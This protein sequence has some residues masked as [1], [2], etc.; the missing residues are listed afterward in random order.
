[1]GALKVLLR[2]RRL[3]VVLHAVLA[4]AMLPGILRLETDN[5]PEIFF[6]RDAAAMQQ[7][8][9]FRRDFGGGRAVRIAL[10]GHGL[11]TPA[12]LD[13]LGRL[14]KQAAALPGVETA[15]GLAALYRWHMLEWPPPKPE[16]F[17]SELLDRDLE[18][19]SGLVS[20]D[21]NTVTMLV[22][23]VDVSPAEERRILY[24]LSE[25]ISPP[26]PDI[27]GR[28]SGLP[29]LHLAMDQS[30]VN[31]ASRF[32]PILGLLAVILLAVIFRRWWDVAVP[33]IFTVLC[34]CVL[35]GIIGYARVRLNLVSII[36]APL[37]F[38]VTLAT[39]VHLLV[40]FRALRQR[41]ETW[42]DAV[43]DTYR[44]K[45]LP[46]LWTGI[47][48]LAAFGSLAAA[49]LPPLRTVGIWS[50]LGIAI[51]TILAFTF[52]PLLLALDPQNAARPVT[53]PFETR[54]RQLG[55][56]WARRSV[57]HRFLVAA[58][59]A[60]TLVIAA[61]GFT[62]LRVED[63]IARYFPERH[64]VRAELE[65]LQ[66]Q[67]VGIYAAELVI[68]DNSRGG[69]TGE[70]EDAG[71]RNPWAQ[72]RLARLSRKL[73]A[74]PL[75]YGAM[76][77]GDLVEATIRSI[78]VEGEVTD[79]V[80]WMAL[81]LMQS[82]PE[83]RALLK[84]MISED[85]RRARVTLLVP[86]ISFS[87]ARPLFQRVKAEA[88]VIFPDADIWI[89]GR[90]PLILSAQ[91]TLLR[92]LIAGLSVTLLCVV[93]IFL[94]LLRSLRFTF[95]VLLPNLWPIAV[96]LGVM[97]W[98]RFPLDSA[99]V[100]TASI[101]LGLAVDDTFHTLG[102]YL[103]EIKEGKHTG[104]SA[105]IEATLE[106]TAPAHILTSIILAA[107]FAACSFSDLLPVSRL[108]TIA[109]AA[110]LLALVGDLLLIPALLS[111]RTSVEGRAE[112]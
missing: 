2:R 108:G 49:G 63:N 60:V 10:G 47:T 28:L 41:G 110:I 97:G 103:R 20:P 25:L 42:R 106:R 40:H 17:R 98:L 80:R 104:A 76:G 11:W 14:E 101:A 92:G 9:R 102:F 77:A 45:G 99:S 78:L 3:A 7:Y 65:R 31:M 46:V 86:M 61:L 89:T 39:A 55:R 75:I 8:S 70:N 21:G 6:A 4:L 1:M 93:V 35:F 72:Q 59:M 83:S 5:S 82:V 64:P 53:R 52:Y 67:G 19:F 13:W 50:A 87:R 105:A 18:F 12:G 43:L 73:R 56:V 15:V 58:G 96:V 79:S 88:A 68:S 24:G 51:M 27:R 74:D 29:V 109:T 91:R 16:L 54:A 107:G 36:L 90:Y 57:N 69:Q 38:V 94:L 95:R 71:F 85:G 111:R 23:L 44:D 30:L 84:T 81:G 34:Q 100:M 48:T 112:I 26:P 37:L 66:F 22:V 32:L 33:L 62:R